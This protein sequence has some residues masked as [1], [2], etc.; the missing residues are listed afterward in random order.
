MSIFMPGTLSAH[1]ACRISPDSHCDSVWCGTCYRQLR[2]YVSHFGEND[3]TP[4]PALYHYSWAVC[5]EWWVV[6]RAD[7]AG[8][9]EKKW[10]HSETQWQDGDEWETQMRLKEPELCC[11]EKR[12][13]K[14]KHT[15]PL[16]NMTQRSGQRIIQECRC[17]WN[18][19]FFNLHTLLNQNGLDSACACVFVYV[20]GQLC[21]CVSI[22]SETLHCAQ[23]QA[24]ILSQQARAKGPSDLLLT[25]LLSLKPFVCLWISNLF[26]CFCASIFLS[27]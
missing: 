20:R 9:K 8:K 22:G 17:I 14:H 3:I 10:Q 13:T 23:S 16:C 7:L 6:V 24:S 4:L 27:E 12:C 1:P 19:P 25:W 15:T 5:K 26:I 18:P 2:R 21:E 11:G